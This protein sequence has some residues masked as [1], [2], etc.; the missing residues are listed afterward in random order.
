MPRRLLVLFLLVAGGA[1]LG[2]EL[3][4]SEQETINQ[5]FTGFP[6]SAGSGHYLR[7]WLLVVLAFVPAG[8]ALIYCGLKTIDRY[9]LKSFLTA[10]GLCIAALL[11]IWVLVDLQ[12]NLSDFK[13]GPTPFRSLGGFYASQIPAISLILIPNALLFSLL[14]VLGRFSATREIVSVIQTGRSLPRL[15][16]PFLIL[17]LAC[18]IVCGIF[19]F[20]WAPEAE[21]QKDILLAQAAGREAS[22]AENVAQFIPEGNRL[23]VVGR[24]PA[25]LSENQTLE[26]VAITVLDAEGD[27]DYR[28][29]SRKARWSL[30]DRV[31]TFQNPLI[32][33]HE[34]PA[35]KTIRPESAEVMRD[36]QE[37]PW[38][39]IQPGLS[40]PDLGVPGLGTWLRTNATDP[41]IDKLP[42][43]T[44]WHYRFAQPWICLVVILLAAP[45][46]IVFSR[47]GTASGTILAVGLCLGMLL[48]TNL[49]L[50]LG[51]AGYIPPVFAAWATNGLFFF[52]ALL[53]LYRRITGRP[54]YQSLRGFFPE[55][56]S[57]RGTSSSKN[58][59]S[60]AA[61]H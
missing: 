13:K 17:G 59:P 27:I 6:E 19:N 20:H 26:N 16:R 30:T 40:A 52:I 2:Y 11:T 3:F 33:R 58:E 49:F 9:L 36:W 21:G 56:F 43:I 32:I 53:L 4:A 60:A 55:S 57:S 14:F 54:I 24:F 23:W 48:S 15:I 18:T 38:Q 51:E 50:A 29:L 22:S 25:D 41:W 44:Q 8:V 42:Y 61:S 47:R 31:W 1:W 45:L 35:P 46:G 34:N 7:P 10:F 37:T 39:I 12:D 5:Q 28:L